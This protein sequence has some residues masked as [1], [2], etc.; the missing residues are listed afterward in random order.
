MYQYSR[1]EVKSLL[2]LSK[3]RG[4]YNIRHIKDSELENRVSPISHPP[5]SSEEMM[6]VRLQSKAIPLTMCELYLLISV[7]V[8][9][10]RVISVDEFEEHGRRYHERKDTEFEREYEVRL[11]G[12]RLALQL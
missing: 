1:P 6:L 4:L 11:Y 8:E 10:M 7:D 2:L 5:Q 3:K 12:D 9:R